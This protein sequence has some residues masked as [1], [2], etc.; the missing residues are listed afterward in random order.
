MKRIKLSLAEIQ[1]TEL[2]IL[3]V[4]HKFC[5]NNYLRYYICGGTLIGAVR[6]KGFIPWDDDIDIIMPR[7]D[8]MKLIELVSSKDGMIGP[9]YKVDTLYLNPQSNSNI[10]RIYDT[11]TELVLKDYRISMNLGCWIDI[12]PMDGVPS[13]V[14]LRKYHYKIARILRIL[15]ICCLTKINMKR[16]TKLLTILQYGMIP[17]LPVIRIIGC[18]RYIKLEEK[19]AQ[20]YKFEKCKYVG[21]I[22]GS[23]GIR[24]TLE[25]EELEPA[26][27]VEFEGE[28][29]YTMANYETY[30]KNMYGDYMTPPP[31]EKRVSRHIIEV[32]KKI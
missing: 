15:E 31:E 27:T 26:V 28:H 19:W 10:P 8:C 7:K 20:K 2:E 13:S 18:K 25:R 9:Y 22:V 1:K 5:E 17:F 4:F 3:K 12:F 11:R 29:F 16:K 6:H 32:Y 30:L 24:E 23:G 21:V 14:L